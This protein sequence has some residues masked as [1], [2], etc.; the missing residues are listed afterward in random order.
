M[1][2]QVIIQKRNSWGRDQITLPMP[3]KTTMMKWQ[4]KSGMGKSEFFRM[5]LMFGVVKVADN[6][7]A[8]THGEGYYS[9]SEENNDCGTVGPA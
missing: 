4:R 6:T 7:L 1:S 3:V 2:E 9:G 5:A 8:K